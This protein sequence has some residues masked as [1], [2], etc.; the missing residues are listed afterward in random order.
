MKQDSFTKEELD[1]AVS[2]LKNN[3][4]PGPNGV[5][6]ELINLLDEEA[7]GKL[8]ELLNKCLEEEELFEEMSQ[9][10][11]AVIYLKGP[12]EKPE[13]YRPIAILSTGYKLMARMVQKRISEAMGDRIDLAQFGFRKGTSTSQPIRIYRRVQE[14]HEEAGLELVTVLLDWEKDFD[15]IHQGRL[16]DALKRIGIPG[17]VVRV[18]EAIY[19]NQKFAIKDIGKRSSE[20]R[21]YS[22]IKQGCPL[23]PYLFI[24]VMTVIMR[25][26]SSKST[27]EERNILRNE[28]PLGMEGHDKLLYADDTMILTSSKQ[29]AEVMLHKIQE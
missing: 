8:L 25:D 26:T 19:R 4:A 28:R 20:R 23:S 1:G 13:N 5:T 7:R 17:N 12:T 24:I 10:D 14:T 3:R 18:I 29:A 2:R 21:Q 22:G 11:L 16:L 6:S 9:A 27:Q 15:K